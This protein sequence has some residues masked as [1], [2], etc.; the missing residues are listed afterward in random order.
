MFKLCLNAQYLAGLD[1]RPHLGTGHVGQ[2]WHFIEIHAGQEHKPGCLRHG[3]DQ[4][5]TGNQRSAGKMPLKNSTFQWNLGPGDNPAVE[6]IKLLDSV[7][8]LEV[9]EQHGE[10]LT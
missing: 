7:D 8:H 9:F 4:Q 3:F 6:G 2:E 5:H 10:T 1:K